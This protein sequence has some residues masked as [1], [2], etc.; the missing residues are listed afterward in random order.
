[1]AR[2]GSGYSNLPMSTIDKSYLSTR[3]VALTLTLQLQDVFVLVAFWLLNLNRSR[4]VTIQL[5]YLPLFGLGD[6][7][8]ASAA[9][10]PRCLDRGHLSAARRGLP[11]LQKGALFG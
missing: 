5:I 11:Q 10:S 2:Y 1:V 8:K 3:N 7:R 4:V 9:W 6:V